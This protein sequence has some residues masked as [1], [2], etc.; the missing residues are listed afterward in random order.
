MNVTVLTLFP[1]L[2]ETVLGE[3]MMRKAASIGAVSFR[4]VNIRD[5]AEGKHLAVDDYP[6][7]G[8][9]G[10]VMK[11]DPVF[12]AIE[13]VLGASAGRARVIL[14]DPRGRRFD[15]TMARELAAET[16][17]VIVCGH[18]E[19]L[20][21]RARSHLI[22]DDVSIGDFVLTGGELPALVIVDA[23]VRL[24]PGV[25]A[26]GGADAES[27]EEGLLEGPH[28]TRPRLYRGSAV[29][30]VLLS[31]HHGHVEEWR[32]KESLR[33]TLLRRPDLLA[34]AELSDADRKLLAELRAEARKR[35]SRK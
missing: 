30:E 26:E 14:T 2:V 19:G 16:D 12:A 10:M 18:Y 17:L 9:A 5:F 23:V 24:L 35:L 13:H 33:R 15:R 6:F 8:G 31:G 28:Y 7:G 21:E 11:P 29:P 1:A 22:T 4:V 32:R 25:L 20:D 34:K 27:F 3:S